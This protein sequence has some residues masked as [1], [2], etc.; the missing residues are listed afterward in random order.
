MEIAFHSNPVVYLKSS[1]VV[2]RN[3]MKAFRVTQ[4]AT[5]F[6]TLVKFQYC[7]D[8]HGIL[9]Y[10]GLPEEPFHSWGVS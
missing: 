5:R 2:I 10:F 1:W 4:D 7:L 9:D 6:A 8:V 3:N